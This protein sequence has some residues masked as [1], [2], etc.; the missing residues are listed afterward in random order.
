[1]STTTG[2]FPGVRIVDMPD[3]GAVTD[4]SSLVGEHAGSGRFGATAFRNYNNRLTIAATAPPA[5][6][7]NISDISTAFTGDLSKA[8]YTVS[9]T[10]SGSNTLGTPS[11]GYVSTQELAANF[12]YL[13]NTS[14]WNQ[15]AG[16]NDGR[17]A[18]A[19]SITKVDNYGQGDCVA[20]LVYGYA[21][22]T[23]SGATYWTACPAISA[24]YAD[25]HAG[26]AHVYLNPVEIDCSDN[27]FDCSA[28]SFVGNLNRTVTTAALDDPWMCVR[29]QSTGTAF[30]DAFLSATGKFTI[31]LD[32]TTAELGPLNSAITLAENQRIFFGSVNSTG[33]PK[34]TNPTGP[35]I[36]STGGLLI[37]TSGGVQFQ[38]GSAS[39]LAN[40]PTAIGG[41]LT[42]L[43]DNVATCGSSARKWSEVW[44]VNGTIQTSDA[45]L[46]T[47]VAPLPEALPLVAAIEPV[48]WRWKQ[49]DAEQRTHWGFLAADVN[50]VMTAS[51]RDFGGYVRGEDGT[52]NLRPDQ[53]IPVMWQALRE[54]AADFAA[55]KS[56]HP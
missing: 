22:S 34:D 20:H 33:W 46:K 18:A 35:Y 24:Y 10:I 3:L 21:A 19:A 31:G 42:P 41:H 38:V 43:N 15:N 54:L 27:G 36:E 44:A 23:K 55:Y 12:A 16:D 28:I 49:G 56:A 11:T 29:G 4:T 39:I 8:G 40:A 32:L 45:R 7:G 50:K 2:T 47:D 51:G 13:K 1:M 9:Y 30:V 48:T 37:L 25:M 26:A 5:S 14:G 52:D 6:L 53:M 17:T